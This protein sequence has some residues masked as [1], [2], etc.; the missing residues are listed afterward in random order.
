LPAGRYGPAAVPSKE[1]D[2][3]W[4]DL[5][6]IGRVDWP[7]R[8][9]EIDNTASFWF[10]GPTKGS[11][12]TQPAFWD[13]A[14]LS[15]LP[16]ET[17]LSDTVEL[18]TKLHVAQHDATILGSFLQWTFWYWRPLIAFRAGDPDHPPIP[19]WTPWVPYN[20]HP[21]YPSLT[22]SIVGAGAAVIQDYFGRK[23]LSV[24][25]FTGF[26]NYAGPPCDTSGSSIPPRNYESLAAAVE[27]AQLGRQYAGHHFNISTHDGAEIG[28][29]A[30]EYVLMH[31]TEPAGPSGVLPDPSVFNLFA[32]RPEKASVASPIEFKF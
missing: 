9:P 4:N 3:Q 10:G 14:L 11:L 18:Y 22:T 13:S 5:K 15:L 8:T 20:L 23:N 27:D 12:C 30:A 24:K 19:D 2:T 29:I 7:G 17:S 16:S 31:W 32:K 28:A 25:P 1:W 6:D 21:E 26:G